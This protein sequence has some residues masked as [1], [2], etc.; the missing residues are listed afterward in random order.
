[1]PAETHSAILCFDFDGTLVDRPSDPYEIARLEEFLMHMQK[2][3]AI[4]GINTGRTLY[5]TLDGLKEHGFR[6]TPD[7][8]IARECEIY[9]LNDFNRWVDL[10]EWNKQCTSDHK[11]FYKAHSKFFKRLRKHVET[12]MKGARF[13][14]D[15]VEP[16]G[17]TT[18]DIND[19][20]K[21][22]AWIEAHKDEW[23]EL[24]YQRNDIW[25]RFNHEGYNKGTALMEVRRVT[26][27]TAEFT[28]AAGDNYNDLPMLQPHI[29]HG[30]AC[31]A[32]AVPD[33]SGHVSN[34]GGY[35]ASE[36]A[37]VGIIAAI[38][39][40]FYPDGL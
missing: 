12:E 14:S 13:L 21:V 36:P 37:T 3:G 39:H 38:E 19:M 11:R 33:I 26:G 16:A 25:L 23:P 6:L 29:A 35:V 24:G 15:D 10:G 30:L 5:H 31:P 18:R 20:A 28:F 7:F 40:Y 2:R 1:M 8:I 9:H 17:L 34:L 27:V 32:N 4:W 22:C